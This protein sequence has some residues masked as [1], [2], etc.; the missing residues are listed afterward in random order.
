[1]TEYQRLLE[2]AG[3]SEIGLE[4]SR[5]YTVADLQAESDGAELL[6]SLPAEAV[7][8]LDGRI[9]SCAITARRPAEG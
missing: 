3:F 5:R 7:Q 4:I 6:T 1:M 2:T 9:T 8:A